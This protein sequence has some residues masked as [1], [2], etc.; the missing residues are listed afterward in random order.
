MVGPVAPAPST[1]VP[2]ATGSAAASRKAVL[3]PSDAALTLRSIA[4]ATSPPPS[5]T[6]ARVAIITV[7]TRSEIA[8][9]RMKK[10]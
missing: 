9:A 6:R 3:R 10:E 4:T 1:A 2:G 8:R 5:A 7:A